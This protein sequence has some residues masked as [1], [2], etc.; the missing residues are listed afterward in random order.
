MASTHQKHQDAK[1]AVSKCWS[2]KGMGVG[3]GTSLL[4]GVGGFIVQA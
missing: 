1:Y 3:V 4:E 2:D